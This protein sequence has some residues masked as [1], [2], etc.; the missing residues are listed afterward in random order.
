MAGFEG[1]VVWPSILRLG[2][3]LPTT[4]DPLRLPEAMR[5]IWPTKRNRSSPAFAAWLGG[6]HHKVSAQC[7]LH[8]YAAHAAWMADHCRLDNGA[9]ANRALGLALDKPVSRQ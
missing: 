5:G 2:G 9:L 3:D 4:L 7:C 8:Q 1:A 6:Q